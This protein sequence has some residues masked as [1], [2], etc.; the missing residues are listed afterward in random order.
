VADRRPPPTIELLKRILALPTS[1]ASA[2]QRM[3]LT[4]YAYH[5]NEGWAAWP[6]QAT[7]ARETGLQ[8]TTVTEIVR[9]LAQQGL[10]R[11]VGTRPNNVAIWRLKLS[12]A[13]T[14]TAEGGCATQAKGGL[15]VVGVA[16]TPCRRSRQ[17]VVGVADTNLP[18]EPLNEPLSPVEHGEPGPDLASRP[19]RKEAGERA[20]CEE[21]RSWQGE[22]TAVHQEPGTRNPPHGGRASQERPVQLALSGLPERE[23]KALVS[24]LDEGRREELL[25]VLKAAFAAYGDQGGAVV[26]GLIRRL[27]GRDLG[28]VWNLR[29][30][31]KPAVE[32]VAAE[33]SR[34]CLAERRR[35]ME[36][37]QRLEAAQAAEEER[38]RQTAGD[39]ADRAALRRAFEALSAEERGEVVRQTKG[40]LSTVVRGHVERQ[41]PDMVESLWTRGALREV[42]RERSAAP[43]HT[44]GGQTCGSVGGRSTVADVPISEAHG[45]PG[46]GTA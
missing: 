33:V 3:V 43:L 40:R 20:S 5:A 39:E 14:S 13:A 46:R 32:Q 35:E 22:S 8:R 16:D 23:L 11:R 45:A 38:R 25:G 12:E 31:C 9:Q 1:A 7:V 44:D 28:R 4:A 6:S 24:G 10:L 26:A 42:M 21:A 29:S 15:P 41:Q 30:Y 18:S 19:L 27:A 37:R 36:E 17:P 34:E 2:T